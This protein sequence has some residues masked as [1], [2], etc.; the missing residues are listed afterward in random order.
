MKEKRKRFT[1]TFKDEAVK[2]VIE[3]SRPIAD[4]AREINVNAGTLGHWVNK[5]REEHAGEEPPL[6]ISERARLKELEAENREL[7][8]ER[9]FLKKAAAFFA[10]EDR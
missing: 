9:E 5:Y 4:V 8:M 7:R 6:Q 1:A 3:T 2:M 10:R